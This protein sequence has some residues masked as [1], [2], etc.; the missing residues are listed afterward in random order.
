MPRIVSVEQGLEE[1]KAH[2]VSCGYDVVD[3]EGMGQ[4]VEAVVYTG[5]QLS[6]SVTP[7][8][9]APENTLLV[10]ASGMSAEQ[11]ARHLV[12]RLG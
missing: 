7:V 6:G 8:L 9:R 12:D 5:P 1:I 3:M 10:N 4:A 2:L 11:V